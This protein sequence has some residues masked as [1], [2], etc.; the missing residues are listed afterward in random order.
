MAFFDAPESV[1]V[2]DSK[3]NELTIGGATTGSQIAAPAAVVLCN[4]K[5]YEWLPGTGVREYVTVSPTG[6][7]T[8]AST[9]NNGAQFGPDT[10]STTTCGIQE[11][12]NSLPVIASTNTT[13]A[14]GGSLRL[15]HGVYVCTS[16]II[17][18]NNF[19]F[20]LRIQGETGLTTV[21]NYNGATA[22]DFIITSNQ[23]GDSGTMTLNLECE[24]VVFTYQPNH[25]NVIM[26][27][28]SLSVGNFTTTGW[29]DYTSFIQSGPTWQIGCPPPASARGVI[30]LKTGPVFANII[31]FQ[32][33]SWLGLAV[34]Y[35]TNSE[36]IKMHGCQFGAIGAYNS[37]SGIVYANTY[38]SD[39]YATGPCFY[40]NPLTSQPMTDIDIEDC[41]FVFSNTAVLDGNNTGSVGAATC[42]TWSYGTVEDCSYM[43]LSLGNKLF[44]MLGVRN[45]SAVNTAST[46]NSSGVISGTFPTS[47]LW[48]DTVTT[49]NLN[50]VNGGLNLPANFNLA[51]GAN[52]CLV[53]SD[54]NNLYFQ[55]VSGNQL[56]F[57]PQGSSSNSSMLL[58]NNN[59]TLNNDSGSASLVIGNNGATAGQITKY[60][61][62][63]TA[64]LGT[65]AIYAS[66]LNVS[67]NTTSTP[68]CSYTPAAAG[69]GQFI[70]SWVLSCKTSSTPNLKVTYTDPNA[71][72]QTITLYNTA[73]TSNN[74]QQGTYSLVAT[75]G[76]AIAVTGTDSIALGDIFASVTI[77]EVS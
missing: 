44:S 56:L 32:N 65:P 36:H 71:G 64:G 6:I 68:V 74:V 49:T 45:I 10:A 52:G 42:S 24:D 59:L 13:L 50:I 18:P 77:A 17:I 43:F 61:N 34:G 62:V 26:N 28:G 60:N 23:V 48:I 14:G 3:G 38:S 31:C 75:S 46:V 29:A 40:I 73:M 55:G 11:A 66:G 53:K 47:L 70:I 54:G 20:S 2:T 7:A 63:N 35:E 8:G 57:R 41:H 9:I 51:L 69:G 16:Q 15:R 5:G 39:L 37:G 76:A 25:Q 67:L 21:V 33:C 12:I 1:V 19:P 58:S 30:G 27:L 22:Q 72:A 4:S